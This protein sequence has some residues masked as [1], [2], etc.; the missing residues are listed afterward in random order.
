MILWLQT[1][2]KVYFT[3]LRLLFTKMCLFQNKFL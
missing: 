1:I 2:N 3:N